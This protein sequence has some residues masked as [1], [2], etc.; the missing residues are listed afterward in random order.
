MTRPT[1][2]EWFEKKHGI[3]FDQLCMGNTMDIVAAIRR[4]LEAVREYTSEMN[5]VHYRPGVEFLAE[6]PEAEGR[7]EMCNFRG[8]VVVA[9]E[10]GPAR[11]ISKRADGTYQIVDIKNLAP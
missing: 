10:F 3:T 4:C 2:D 8:M 1:F 7:V 5:A 9:S 6:I 11:L